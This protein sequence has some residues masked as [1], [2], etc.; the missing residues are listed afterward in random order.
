MDSIG[1]IFIIFCIRFWIVVFLVVCFF[2]R[3]VNNIIFRFFKFFLL[4]IFGFW[5]LCDCFFIIKNNIVIFINIII[6]IM[7]DVIF[8]IIIWL[9]MNLYWSLYIM[10]LVRMVWCL[11]RRCVIFLNI[12]FFFDFDNVFLLVWRVV[13]MEICFYVF[14]F[15]FSLSNW[16]FKFWGN[17]KIFL[18]YVRIWLILEI[19]MLI[20][21]WNVFES[22]YFEVFS[23]ILIIIKLCFF[24][25]LLRCK[26]FLII[27]IE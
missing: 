18:C 8:I 7:V 6:I 11:L 20:Y 24:K 25:Y 1:K 23:F 3:F 17:I 12:I 2:W 4:D 9:I 26:F 5:V 22:S 21:S 16:V 13:C 19:F 15:F 27:I 10:V 14:L